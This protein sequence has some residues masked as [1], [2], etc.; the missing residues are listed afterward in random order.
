MTISLH[1][2]NKASFVMVL[3]EWND[4][5]E[6]IEMKNIINSLRPSDAYMLQ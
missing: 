1:A 4:K 2:A 6:E 5:V 3:S